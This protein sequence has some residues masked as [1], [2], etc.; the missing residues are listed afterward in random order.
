[1]GN[2]GLSSLEAGFATMYGNTALSINR[3]VVDSDGFR[4]NNDDSRSITGAMVHTALTDRTS[5]QA[6]YTKLHQSSGD[7]N[8]ALDGFFDPARRVVQDRDTLRLGVRHG[9]S[10][11]TEILT[12]FVYQDR[13]E[14]FDDFGFGSSSIATRSGRLELQGLHRYD[15]AS[16]VVGASRYAGRTEESFLVAPVS[17]PNH[18]TA[19]GYFGLRPLR[20]LSTQIGMSYDHLQARESM[21][22]RRWNP[23]LSAVWDV[24]DHTTLRAALFQTVKRRVNAEQGLEP[25]Q[26]AGFTHYFD[27]VNGAIA[28]TASVGVDQRWNDRLYGGAD[29]TRRS[30]LAPTTIVDQNTG[31]PTA[32]RREQIQQTLRAYMAWIWRPSLVLSAMFRRESLAVPEPERILAFEWVDVVTYRAPV[33]VRGY[34]GD[35]WFTSATTEFVRQQGRMQLFDTVEDHRSSGNLLHFQI[36]RLLPARRGTVVLD[37][38]NVF[39][40]R[41]LYQNTFIETEARLPAIALARTVTLRIQLW[42]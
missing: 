11:S 30:L 7:L 9:L 19:Y 16:L 4:A 24:S 17:H 38:Q 41:L 29:L 25:A 10:P 22:P 20:N 5:V 21:D 23:K 15:S 27:D 39:D 32:I 13:S 31:E 28:R 1:V 40:R 14:T 12:S 3:F 2:R 42:L 8:L 26:F 6:E 33:T 36:G 37:A 18:F 34:F 35:G